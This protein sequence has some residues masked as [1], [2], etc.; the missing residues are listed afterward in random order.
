[1]K[2]T[3]I[4][5]WLLLSV[6]M[7]HGQY[8]WWNQKHGWDGKTHWSQYMILSPA[9]LGPNA[10]PVPETHKGI[11]AQGVQLEMSYLQHKGAGDQTSNL[12]NRLFIPLYSSRA[13]LQ[14][15]IVP[16]EYFSNDTI[17]RDIR[18][19]R[20]MEGKGFSVGDLYLGTHIQLIQGHSTWPDVLLTLNL[21][22]A[23]GTNLAS[24]RHTDTPGYYFDLSAGKDYHIERK[25]FNRIR[26]FLSAG[27]YVWQV[28]KTYYQNDAFLYGIGMQLRVTDKLS[29]TGSLAGYS[30]YIGNGDK[31]SVIRTRLEW[32]PSSTTTFHAG[33]QKGVRDYLYTTFHVGIQTTLRK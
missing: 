29:F 7:C 33:F 4:F 12:Y 23:S 6:M 20:N 13:G 31:P 27:F 25:Y 22:T 15:Q 10:L 19:S 5:S 30:G 14:L 32:S 28:N 16:V 11:I 1:M 18:R 26:P 2:R 21:K 24:A 17:T 3:I 8:Y 9:Y